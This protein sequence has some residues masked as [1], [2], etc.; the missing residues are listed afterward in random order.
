MNIINTDEAFI[1][2]KL[3]PDTEK[4]AYHLDTHHWLSYINVRSTP[5]FSD[6]WTKNCAPA[7]LP[8]RRFK[9]TICLGV[10]E[11]RLAVVCSECSQKICQQ[12]YG[13]L[14]DYNYSHEYCSSCSGPYF[15]ESLEHV[16]AFLRRISIKTKKRR[17]DDDDDEGA[18]DNNEHAPAKRFKTET[19]AP[20]YVMCCSRRV[21]S[22]MVCSVCKSTY[23]RACLNTNGKGH[24]CLKEDLKNATCIKD[25]TK[26]CPKCGVLIERSQGCTHMFCTQCFYS[27]D[28]ETLKHVTNSSNPLFVAHHTMNSGH[29]RGRVLRH[30]RIEDMDRTPI[31]GALSFFRHVESFYLGDRVTVRGGTHLSRYKIA[32]LY[33]IILELSRTILLEPFYKLFEDY[34]AVHER[35]VELGKK[36]PSETLINILQLDSNLDE[37]F[38]HLCYD[39]FIWRSGYCSDPTFIRTSSALFAYMQEK[40]KTYNEHNDLVA[41]ICSLLNT[42][43]KVFSDRFKHQLHIQNISLTDFERNNRL[44]SVISSV[45]RIGANMELENVPSTKEMATRRITLSST[46]KKWDNMTDTGGQ[47]VLP[48]AL[49]VRFSRPMDNNVP[50]FYDSIDS[51]VHDTYSDGDDEDTEDEDIE[52]TEDTEEDEDTADTEDTE[53]TE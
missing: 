18:D 12:C 17:H 30:L 35:V 24:K 47:L 5:Y 26:P 32:K 6:E 14:L 25:R 44:A 48:N 36:A 46:L 53:D 50:D 49:P 22:K 38:I 20:S 31:S 21:P 41:Q 3:L 27:F 16:P 13:E 9:C 1:T 28:W 37:K 19:G 2:Y 34:N 52:D 51:D 39:R 29:A 4:S 11:P 7:P 23:C 45:L 33:T 10:C 40:F 43:A 8:K 15:V 42:N